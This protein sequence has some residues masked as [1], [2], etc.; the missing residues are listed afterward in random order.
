MTD[1]APVNVRRKQIRAP[2]ERA[3]R[4][5][6]EDGR[7]LPEACQVAGLQEES[8]QKALRK[9]H[10]KAFCSS[11][12]REWMTGQTFR[13]WS[14]VEKLRDTSASDKVRLES[15][16]LFIRA[17]GDLEPERNHGP[18]TA[19]ALQIIVSPQHALPVNNTSAGGVIEAPPFDPDAFRVVHPV[20]RL[21]E[22]SDDD[23]D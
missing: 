8:V 19:L 15:A 1:T 11:L 23:V 17:A 13:S 2:L 10:V 5:I 22:P 14:T 3:I 21:P 16:A 20:E 12:K 6:I 4:L 9:E 18:S 7:T